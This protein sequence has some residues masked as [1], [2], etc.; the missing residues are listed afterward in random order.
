MRLARRL[1]LRDL[2]QN[3]V[4]Q[5]R[6]RLHLD[7]CRRPSR[8]VPAVR[9]TTP[10]PPDVSTEPTTQAVPAVNKT[11]G[12]RPAASADPGRALLFIC[13]RRMCRL[14]RSPHLVRMMRRRPNEK[15]VSRL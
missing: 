1:I 6:S 13:I 2:T 12:A 14:Q 3:L 8:S 4:G 7:L 5:P 10:L 11:S 9:P 15:V